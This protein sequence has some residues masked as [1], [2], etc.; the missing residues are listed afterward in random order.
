MSHL[1]PT[2]YMSLALAM[3]LYGAAPVGAQTLAMAT[4]A[5]ESV[6]I[7]QPMRSSTSPAL[8]PRSVWRSALVHWRACRWRAVDITAPR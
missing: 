8:P 5:D 4:S 3:Q 7:S 2:I 6:R 1:R